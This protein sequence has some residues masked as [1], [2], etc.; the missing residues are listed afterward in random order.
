[1]KNLLQSA[2]V[3]LLACLTAQGQTIIADNYNVLNV[4]PNG[5]ALGDGREFRD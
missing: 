3:L 5:F 2:A 4:A 1:M